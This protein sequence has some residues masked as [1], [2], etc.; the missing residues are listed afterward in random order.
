MTDRLVAREGLG[1]HT[2]LLLGILESRDDKGKAPLH[3][4]FHK[5]ASLH[6]IRS[7]SKQMN[8]QVVF[9]ERPEIG[10]GNK[11]NIQHHHKTCSGVQPSQVSPSVE[12]P[13]PFRYLE[14]GE[15]EMDVDIG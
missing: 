11:I 2:I 15:N 14:W 4:P 3:K 13:R 7:Q 6:V 12:L 5:H 9:Y 1:I 10:T 8:L